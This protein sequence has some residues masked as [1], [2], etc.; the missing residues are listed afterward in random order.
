MH[1]GL[2]WNYFVQKSFL[3]TFDHKAYQWIWLMAESYPNLVSF[4]NFSRFELIT[5]VSYAILAT[6]LYKNM[7]WFKILTLSANLLSHI[8]NSSTL[9]SE[10]KIWKLTFCLL[11]RNVAKLGRKRNS[12]WNVITMESWK[13]QKFHLEKRER[14][15]G[16]NW[17]NL[18]F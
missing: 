18:A 15:G 1:T 6:F 17:V 5:L 4:W 8:T 10:L 13:R 12:F 7:N 14:Q 2:K 9:F 16:K 11:F 3:G